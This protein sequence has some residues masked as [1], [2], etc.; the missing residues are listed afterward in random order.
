MNQNQKDQI[1]KRLLAERERAVRAVRALDDSVGNTA[2]DGDITLYPFHL[3]DEGTDTINQ[4][5]SLLLL[6]NEGRL[7]MDIDEA[8]RRLY[9]DDD[10]FGRCRECNAEIAFERLDIV[11]WTSLCVDHQREQE[12]NTAVESESGAA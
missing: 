2:E 7:L 12:E 3:A 1:E 9:R 4:E 8:L 11:P 6:S 10:S 5:Q